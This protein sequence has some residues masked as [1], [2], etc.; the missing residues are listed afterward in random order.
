MKIK[1]SVGIFGVPTKLNL[2]VKILYGKNNQYEHKVF[3]REFSLDKGGH[4]ELP[5]H[6]FG[7]YADKYIEEKYHNIED[8]EEIIL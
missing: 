1:I 3:R 7:D 4:V 8:K 2:D 5:I 6:F